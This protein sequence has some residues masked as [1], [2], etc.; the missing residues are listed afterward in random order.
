MQAG[1]NNACRGA[2]F[3]FCSRSANSRSRILPSLRNKPAAVF[4]LG[5]GV[6]FSSRGESARA[7]TGDCK[8]EEKLL[9]PGGASLPVP[10]GDDEGVTSLRTGAAY[11]ERGE[12]ASSR[13]LRTS[14]V[15]ADGDADGDAASFNG[16]T[17]ARNAGLTGMAPALLLFAGPSFAIFSISDQ[18]FSIPAIFA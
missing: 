8:L 10:L 13:A 7:P 12:P 18:H 1:V 5:L 4:V 15:A 9:S 3:T 16:G 14:A 17:M 11:G 6:A 2:A